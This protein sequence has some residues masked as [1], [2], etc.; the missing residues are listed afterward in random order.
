MNYELI[1]VR[2]FISAVSMRSFPISLQF[3][4]LKLTFNLRKTEFQ[5]LKHYTFLSLK[6]K[7]ITLD[8]TKKTDKNCISAGESD[9]M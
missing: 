1:L 3:V 2:Y 9:K 6:S 5:I 4:F 8:S 7:M